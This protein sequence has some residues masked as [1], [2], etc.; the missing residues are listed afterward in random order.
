MFLISILL[1]YWKFQNITIS[2]GFAGCFGMVNMLLRSDAN[3]NLRGFV[4]PDTI[5]KLERCRDFVDRE[6]QVS[7][8]SQVS[9]K[10]STTCLTQR[11]VHQKEPISAR[12]FVKLGILNGQS[13]DAMQKDHMQQAG[14]VQRKRSSPMSVKQPR[15]PFPTSSTK[16]IEELY[17]DAQI[18]IKK[19]A[20]HLLDEVQKKVE[21]LSYSRE[22]QKK[23]AYDPVTKSE[24]SVYQDASN[25]LCKVRRDIRVAFKFQN[26]D[27]IIQ[28][29]NRS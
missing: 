14:V 6:S 13:L 15:S 25:M 16:Q 20:Q 2:C 22:A 1:K 26:Q 29:R 5:N 7:Q 12:Q 3:P 28:F 27:L 11:F 24:I 21:K 9:T 23:Y 18:E 10:Q 8:V 19:E 4:D 17:F